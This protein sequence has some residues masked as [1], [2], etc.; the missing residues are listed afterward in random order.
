M[1]VN[2]VAFLWEDHT[3]NNTD[4]Q[5]KKCLFNWNSITE[6]TKLINKNICTPIKACLCHSS[7][8]STVFWSWPSEWVIFTR[9]PSQE[10]F[11]CIQTLT[12]S[13]FACQWVFRK[14]DE[15]MEWQWWK[16]CNIMR[17]RGHWKHLGWHD[18]MPVLMYI[19]QPDPAETLCAHDSDTWTWERTIRCNGK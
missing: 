12:V 18:G 10:S 16:F 5:K 17:G 19:H 2:T 13:P 4:T 14:T 1:R 11:P 6:I 3:T 8:N 15:Q 7:T 9:S